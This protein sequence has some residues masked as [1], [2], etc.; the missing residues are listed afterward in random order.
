MGPAMNIENIRNFCIIAHID[1]GKSTLADRFLEVTKTVD[2][3]DLKE[4]TLDTMDL[5]RERGITIKLQPAKM[6]YKG[7][8]LNLIDTPGHVD[9]AYEVSRS[10]AAVEGD[11]LVV[12]ASQGIEA[13]TL[14]TLYAAID[15]GLE[16]IPVVNKIDLPHAEPEKVAE[17]I[18]NLLGCPHEDII[19][20]SGKT[21][22]GVED[23]LDRIIERVPEPR[24]LDDKGPKA[25][26]FDSFYDSYK[27][28]ITYVR[29]FNG[30]LKKGEKITLMAER[31]PA[32]VLEIGYLKPKFVQTDG[33]GVGEIGYVVTGLKE[34]KKARV[35]DTITSSAQMAKEALAGYQRVKPLV[36]AGLFTTEGDDFPLLREALGKLS[37]SDSSLEY[38]PENSAALGFGFRCGFLGLLH[39]EIVKERLER[40]FNLDLIATSPSVSY[41]IVKTNGETVTIT[42]PADLPEITNIKEIREPFVKL[43]VVTPSDYI[44]PIMDLVQKR[45]GIY[46]N[47][48][49]LDANRAV[50]E[51]EV[52]LSGI[53]TDFFDQLKS[54]S[55]GYASLNYDF[56]G[57]RPENLVKV[58]VLI[59]GQAFDTLALIVHKSE[60]QR[61]GEE[62]TKK[63]KDLI[64]RQNFKIP[65]QA[66]IGGKIIAREDIPAFRKDV[67]AK[68]YGGDVTRKRKLLE[69]QKKGKKRMKMVGNVEIPSD[70][71]I[72]LLKS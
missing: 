39:M 31:T 54:I 69:K 18:I 10:L 66:A 19:F 40:E 56:L 65:I 25:L 5:E 63:L 15:A 1:H 33:L 3:R 21:G 12:D 68:L 29:M 23:V 49:Y 72:K 58:D 4:Q 51:Y 44:G 50:L 60:A 22:Q 2:K 59:N 34:V 20:A 55:S 9:F 30:G 67:T 64:P 70:T 14:S 61:S 53:V 16:I 36:F 13:Q 27:G 46:K 8:T 52:P 35:G 47:T 38:E 48:S 41:E 24:I 37:L 6:D 62:F 42:S 26:I 45:H 71:F 28:V 7:Y 17:E 57:Y 32:E 43:E 11:L